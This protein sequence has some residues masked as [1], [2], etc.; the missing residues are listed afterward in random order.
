MNETTEQRKEEEEAS[1]PRE[2]EEEVLPREEAAVVHQ[3]RERVAGGSK[4]KEGDHW[5][6]VDRSCG[7]F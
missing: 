3:G 1:E 4:E 5:H 6:R 7:K 2:E